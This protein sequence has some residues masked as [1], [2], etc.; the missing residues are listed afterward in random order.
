MKERK[1]K[2][3]VVDDDQIILESL[4]EMLSLEG[5]DVAGATGLSSALTSLEQAPADVVI[6]D[7]NL[8]GGDGFEL[9]QV[10]RKRWP[11]TVVIMIT[12]YG[13]IESAVE[14]IKM[15][16]YDYLTKP[17]IDDELR[18]VV[19]RALSQQSLILENNELKQKLDMRFGLGNLVG[20]DYRMQKIY[21]L[22]EAVSDSKVT[23]L[24]QGESGTGKSLVARMIHHQSP[25]RDKPCIEVACGAIPETL[26]ESELFGH[27]RGSF[28]GAVADKIGKFKAADEGTLFLDEIATASPALQVKLLRALQSRQFEAVGSNKTETVDV[29]LVLATNKNLEEEVAAGNFR[30]D[31]FYRINVVTITMPTLQ[32]RVGD[33][34]LLASH[35]LD[36]FCEESNRTISGFSE[37]A[38]NAMQRYAWPGNV[39]ELENAVERAV[40][41]SKGNEIDIDDLPPRIIE[42][43][44][45]A[46]TDITFPN[47]SLKK[48]LEGPERTVIEAALR[49]NNWNR[50]QTAEML[51]I[52][53]TTLYKK[54]RRYG[55]L[56][57]P[58]GSK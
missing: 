17:I 23:V 21:D 34:P 16:A 39:R 27:I 28:T 35:F 46:P 56:D 58:V 31:L 3:F 2:I 51:D 53:R 8:S 4:Q 13:T 15:G 6:S 11:E 49:V 20:Q 14:A 9:L 54:M 12:G 1:H 48:A 10:I 36:K 7:I 22:I 45:L 5:Y 44:Q 57:T 26:L 32:E 43:G 30:E 37:G 47:T 38:V 41:L 42:Q 24:V 19:E 29:R 25:R 55:L 18:L 33:I 50:Q 52:N 40:V